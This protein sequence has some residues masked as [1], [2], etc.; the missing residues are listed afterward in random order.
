MSEYGLSNREADSNEAFAELASK[1]LGK[2][3]F[4]VIDD[5]DPFSNDACADWPVDVHIE[6]YYIPLDT[7]CPPPFE[8]TIPNHLN[9]YDK[10]N[11]GPLDTFTM[12][13]TL[14]IIRD[15]LFQFTLKNKQGITMTTINENTPVGLDHKTL[16]GL[17]EIR[18]LTGVTRIAEHH[19]TNGLSCRSVKYAPLLALAGVD[20]EA[21]AI[22][23]AEYFESMGFMTEARPITAGPMDR[24]SLVLNAYYIE[25]VK[26]GDETAKV[27]TNLVHCQISD[28]AS[29]IMHY[30]ANGYR[31]SLTGVLAYLLPWTRQEPI[32]VTYVS[33][34]GDNGPIQDTREIQPARLQAHDVFYPQL[35]AQFGSDVIEKLATEFKQHKSNLLLLI[36]PPG[37][38]KSTLLRSMIANMQDYNAVQF[39]GEKVILDPRFDAC[40]AN[41][42]A[43][44]LIIVEDADNLV[45]KRE[46]GNTSM[47][48]LLNEIDGIADKGH[49]FIISTNLPTV[50]D[51]DSALLR[52]GRL[53]REL[54][55]SLYTAE[56]AEAIADELKLPLPEGR[57]DRMSLAE[58]TS[59]TTTPILV[60]PKFGF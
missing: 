39:A 18:S 28:G 44:S 34:F 10:L 54:E 27:V 36:G 38:G 7:D 24:T 47:S 43:K 46:D 33:G 53:A 15:A 35:Q 49:K 29:S 14:L 48:L 16:E 40:L 42:P 26:Q 52:P 2:L 57:H 58:V 22:E 19:M 30:Y 6:Y 32:K 8:L 31:Q 5:D 56:Q 50:R 1:F 12:P 55:F 37:T 13:R 4:S 41:L 59:G 17:L 20:A 25:S 45:R 3:V 11:N 9:P 23:L 51:I 21:F 60:R